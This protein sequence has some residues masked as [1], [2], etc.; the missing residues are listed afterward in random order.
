MRCALEPMAQRLGLDY[1]DSFFTPPSNAP[2]V[3]L[4]AY[5]SGLSLLMTYTYVDGWIQTDSTARDRK[6]VKRSAKRVR[7]ELLGPRGPDAISLMSQGYAREMGALW[8]R[9]VG[10]SEDERQKLLEFARRSEAL[11]DLVAQYWPVDARPVSDR[12][13]WAEERRYFDPDNPHAKVDLRTYS[14]RARATCAAVVVLVGEE[15]EEEVGAMLFRV[16]NFDLTFNT[17]SW[18]DW[19]FE[20]DHLV[21][22]LRDDPVSYSEVTASSN[23][24][25]Q[26]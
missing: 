2:E 14:G 25:H 17:A 9:A 22:L 21:N 15:A 16:M 12:V 24:L 19:N 11:G 10:V 5:R 23:A 18:A 20:A 1:D 3:A 13:A 7:A 4:Y 26:Q 6:S 8:R